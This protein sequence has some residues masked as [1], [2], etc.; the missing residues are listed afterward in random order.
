[1]FHIGL[2]TGLVEIGLS[3]ITW[4]YYTI[5]SVISIDKIHNNL[6]IFLFNFYI[7]FCVVLCYNADAEKEPPQAAAKRRNTECPLPTSGIFLPH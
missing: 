2:T 6:C 4:I 3:L 5:I 1:M 7:E